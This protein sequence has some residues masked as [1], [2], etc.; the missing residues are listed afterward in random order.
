[1]GDVEFLIPELEGVHVVGA[2]LWLGLVT[3]GVQFVVRTG[4]W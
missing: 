1:M 4:L 2:G 3:G